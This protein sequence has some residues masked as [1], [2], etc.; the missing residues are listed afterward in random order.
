MRI[1]LK[2]I[3]IIKTN[4]KII[5]RIV[6]E[7]SNHFVSTYSIQY[8]REV[9]EKELK[10]REM[11][12]THDYFGTLWTKLS[13]CPT[14]NMSIR[15]HFNGKTR[16]SKSFP[17]KFWRVSS[18]NNQSGWNGSDR[19]RKT[20]SA[21]LVNPITYAFRENVHRIISNSLSTR[22]THW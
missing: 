9:T 7:L 16:V 17:F 2:I 22:V 19:E 8:I 13:C 15:I 1:M 14:K 6:W 11:Y 5:L 21:I 12:I 20:A 18:P 4:L 10:V 3:K